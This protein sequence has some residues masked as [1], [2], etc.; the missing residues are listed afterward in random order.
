MATIR[1][2]GPGQWHVQIRRTGWPTKTRTFAFKKDAE[3]WAR[4]VE[5]QMDRGVF[6]DRSAAERTTLAKVIERYLE[7]VTDKRPGEASRVAERARLERFLREEPALC[8]YAVANLRPEHFEEYRDRRLTQVVS[9]GRSGGREQDRPEETCPPTL[10]KDGTPR[11]NAAKPKAAP[12]L[13]KLVEPGTV[14]RELTVLKRAIDHSKRRLGL[15]V[16]PLNTEDVKRPVV[17]DQRD[18]RL[19]HGEIERLLDA[20]RAS[21]NPWLAPLVDLAFETGARRSSLLRLRWS[22][23]DLLERSAL[24]RGV[25]NSRNPGERLDQLIGLSPRAV[26]IL[27]ELAQSPDGR[28]FPISADAVKCAFDRARARAG[29]EHFNF[30]DTRHERA[31]SLIEAGW[32]DSQVMAQ[33]GHRD[34]KSLKRYI[35][36]RKKFLADALAALPKRAAKEADPLARS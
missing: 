5:A 30:H 8:A 26:E 35:N 3:A 24:L 32:S 11:K 36:L 6:V 15:T 19:D 27:E 31:S 23:T 25:K 10:R 17:N 16:N 1:E 29:L 20:C 21:R 34:P 14:K 18:V 7:E 22:D 12:K 9:R 28:V 13:P 33:T 4:A 2:K